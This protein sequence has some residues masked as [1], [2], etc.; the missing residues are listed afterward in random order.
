M[1]G[2]IEV[3]S[4]QDALDA[5]HLY[6]DRLHEEITPFNIPWEHL[7]DERNEAYR[8]IGWL[9]ATIRQNND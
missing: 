5:I 4:D 9:K 1:P 2:I 7:R 6:I 8:G 3:H